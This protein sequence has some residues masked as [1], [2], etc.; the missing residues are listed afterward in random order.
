M[1]YPTREQEKEIRKR[2]SLFS[3]GLEPEAAEIQKQARESPWAPQNIMRDYVWDPG[4][5]RP[6]KNTWADQLERKRKY[7]WEDLSDRPQ[8][9]EFDTGIQTLEK[10]DY[11]LGVEKRAMD[12]KNW[13]GFGK[14]LSN[15][16]RGGTRTSVDFLADLGEGIMGIGG[17][18]VDNPFTGK[19][20]GAGE[21]GDW[22]FEPGNIE[23]FGKA[24]MTMIEP[25]LPGKGIDH[26]KYMMDIINDKVDIVLPMI[27]NWDIARQTIDQKKAN[28]ITPTKAD[29]TALSDA[30]K[31]FD[32]AG[33]QSPSAF[34]NQDDYFDSLDN[35]FY[36]E[37]SKDYLKEF[38]GDDA[39]F[40]DET[41]DIKGKDFGAFNKFQEDLF[42]YE[43]PEG[44]ARFD[45]TD[46]SRIGSDFFG[47]PVV[48]FVPEMV[49]FGGLAKLAT[50]GVK[51]TGS[52]ILRNIMPSMTKPGLVWPFVQEGLQ[53]GGGGGIATLYEALRDK[54]IHLSE[55]RF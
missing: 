35:K 44:T 23:G 37:A 51:K 40:D 31:T 46:H 52:G 54:N 4:D 20:I 18:G 3:F 28:G 5:K 10:P 45:K 30:Q 47:D 1:E 14:D 11:W 26:D 34:E 16:W 55:S 41:G 32:K 33:I 6:G 29:W 36:K 8:I 48:G 50:Q 13:K 25:W 21:Y 38:W 53:V 24:G 12:P 17:L 27:E 49:T 39:Y 43:H 15:W 19:R 7:W 2:R 9:N 42:D 22:L